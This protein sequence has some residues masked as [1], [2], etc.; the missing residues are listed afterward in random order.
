MVVG[1]WGEDSL[2]RVRGASGGRVEE[3]PWVLGCS[4][5]SK[6][7]LGQSHGAE[8][9][10][11]EQVPA[12]EFQ[13]DRQWHGWHF[14]HSS[15]AETEAAFEGAVGAFAAGAPAVRVAELGGLFVSAARR[16]LRGIG[17]KLNA[18]VGLAGG[19]VALHAAV[20]GQRAGGTQLR[21]DQSPDGVLLGVGARRLRSMAIRAGHDLMPIIK[22]EP[23]VAH[24]VCVKGLAAGHGR[25]QRDAQFPR[26]IDVRVAA[27]RIVRGITV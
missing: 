25:G 13:G 1:W 10:S 26:V 4:T 12:G 6:G 3:Y 22:R 2:W 17:A 8:G 15:S 16:G 27:L 9:H 20:R 18:T 24:F 21:I 11:A 19:L 7:L 5:R 14:A 23:I